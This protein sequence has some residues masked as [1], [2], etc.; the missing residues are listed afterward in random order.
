MA[1][2]TVDDDFTITLGEACL[3]WGLTKRKVEWAVWRYQVKARQSVVGHAWLISYRSCVTLWGQPT[4]DVI[5]AEI[6]RQLNE[7]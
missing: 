1:L 4:A 6:V 7:R 3:L 2:V 5:L